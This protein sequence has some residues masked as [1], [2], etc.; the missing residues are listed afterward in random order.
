V[1]KCVEKR[2]DYYYYYYY[3]FISTF[4]NY[5][6]TKGK[7]HWNQTTKED[8][9]IEQHCTRVKCHRPKSR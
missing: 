7:R 9:E 3:F 8:P 2:V 6:I 1:I 4:Q 5:K